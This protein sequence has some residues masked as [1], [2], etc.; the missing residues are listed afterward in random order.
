MR[1][2]SPSTGSNRGC[3]V[4]EQVNQLVGYLAVQNVSSVRKDCR[5]R[6]RQSGVKLVHVILDPE[7]TIMEPG[8]DQHGQR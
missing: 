5:T 1:R 6:V 3:E 8:H 4:S 2:P 7:K